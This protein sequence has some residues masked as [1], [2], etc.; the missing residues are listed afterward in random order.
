[1]IKLNIC[2]FV[3][4]KPKEPSCIVNTLSCKDKTSNTVY[5]PIL[6]KQFGQECVVF[7]VNLSK[8]TKHIIPYILKINKRI[9]LKIIPIQEISCS[10]S[11]YIF[12]LQKGQTHIC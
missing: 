11:V 7:W 5:I 12:I 6:F 9:I 1:M 4:I 10:T 3:I 8:I 2:F